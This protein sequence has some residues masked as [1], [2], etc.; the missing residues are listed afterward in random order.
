MPK[1]K[2]VDTPFSLALVTGASSGL[3]A[4]LSRL[5][6]SEGVPLLITARDEQALQQLAEQLGDKVSVEIVVADLSDPSQREVLIEKIG[7]KVPDLIINNAGFGRYGSAYADETSEQMKILQVNAE[8]LLQITLEGA[9]AMIRN[10][11]EG[12]IMNV[13][14]AA[15]ILTFPF[16]S[17]YAASKAFVTQ[18]SLSLD[19]ELRPQGVRVLTASPG[20][21]ETQFRLRASRGL[22]ATAAHEGMEASFAAKKLLELIKNRKQG[23]V[24]DWKVKIARCLATHLLPRRWLAR[25]LAANIRSYLSH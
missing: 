10:K 5:L 20:V 19:E 1:V 14:S 3:G 18:V 17:V 22:T 11:K 8:A 2:S 9:K 23:K 24:F 12:V 7:S 16:S 25:Y 15:D 13:S 21:I 6:A 4:H